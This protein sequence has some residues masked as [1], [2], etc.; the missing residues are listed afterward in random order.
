MIAQCTLILEKINVFNSIQ[1][2]QQYSWTRDFNEVETT[3]WESDRRIF[4]NLVSI[5]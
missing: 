4:P 1:F 5:H 2:D 3:G